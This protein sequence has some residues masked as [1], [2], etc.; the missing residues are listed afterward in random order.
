MA[1]G[2]TVGKCVCWQYWWRRLNVGAAVLNSWIHNE[3]LLAYVTHIRLH[4][5]FVLGLR[6]LDYAV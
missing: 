2:I 5:L 1:T 3:D 4:R 6:Q